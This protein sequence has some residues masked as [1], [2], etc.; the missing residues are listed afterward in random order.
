MSYPNTIDPKAYFEVIDGVTNIDSALFNKYATIISA[1]QN[2]LGIK[3]SGNY[4]SVRLRLD[5]MSAASESGAQ[6]N[7]R[8]TPHSFTIN[9]KYTHSIINP[10]ILIGESVVVP[11]T[12]ARTPIN[13]EVEGGFAD[14][15]GLL[16]FSTCVNVDSDVSLTLSVVDV[17]AVPTEIL[18]YTFSPGE[19]TYAAAFPQT[20][21]NI[22]RTYEFRCYQTSELSEPENITSTIWNT[23]LL[24]IP[25]NSAIVGVNS[26][27]YI[28][29]NI[30]GAS[31]ATGSLYLG[32]IYGP[33]VVQ[34]VLI[35]IDEAFDRGTTITI[36]DIADTDRLMPAV[37]NSPDIPGIYSYSPNHE[38]LITFGTVIRAYFSGTITTGSGSIIIFYH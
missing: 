15:Y 12:F 5:A 35:Q 4:S 29:V 26:A 11:T 8:I 36:G 18:S 17:T 7:T 33:G 38:Y 37:D 31:A 34:S 14:G 25:D 3:P 24:F 22:D 28:K 13:L 32:K 6:A 2:E 9:S 10:T 16:L 19:H 27:R 20:I 23:R 30:T 1:L 21:D